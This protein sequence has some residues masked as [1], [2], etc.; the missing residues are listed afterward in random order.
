MATEAE[1]EKVVNNLI[2]SLYMGGKFSGKVSREKLEELN[3]EDE[4]VNWDSL[5]CVEA[6]MRYVV[7]VEE[8]SPDAY[9]FKAWMK[10]EL[11]SRGY[12]VE[13][14]TEW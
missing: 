12:D 6:S 2:R 5:R 13:V 11:K 4:P 14:V 10:R 7:I 8:A 3:L 1:I 9:K